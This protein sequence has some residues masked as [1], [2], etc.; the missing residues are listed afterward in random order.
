MKVRHGLAY[1][2]ICISVTFIKDL[3]GH[4]SRCQKPPLYKAITFLTDSWQSL[5]LHRDERLN[6]RRESKCN[7]DRGGEWL[8]RGKTPFP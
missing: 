4:P 3:R 1:R 7:K 8:E 2:Q 5:L 6:A